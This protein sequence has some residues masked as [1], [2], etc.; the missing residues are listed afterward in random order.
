MV[1]AVE[2]EVWSSRLQRRATIRL[3]ARAIEPKSL[4]RAEAEIH[5]QDWAPCNAISVSRVQS[6]RTLREKSA[7]VVV[8]VRTFTAG[9]H[10][11]RAS[12]LGVTAVLRNQCA[13]AEEAYPHDV[14]AILAA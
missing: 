14:I 8:P 5:S 1:A 11:G 3:R 6:G 12:A 10:V 9:K 2:P 4:R 13:I 7:E